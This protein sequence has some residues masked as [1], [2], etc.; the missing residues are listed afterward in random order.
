MKA[1]SSSRRRFLNL[2]AFL[3]AWKK[4]H[5]VGAAQAAGAGEWAHLDGGVG[6]GEAIPRDVP[7]GHTVV[8]V[9]EELRRYVV[10]VSSLDHPLFRELL[11][12][13]RDEYGFA[14]ADTRLCI[15]CDEDAFL[16]V[17]CHVDA[18]RESRLALCS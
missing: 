4:L 15:P 5:L 2:R 1:G 17:L 12:R 18:E 9:G 3:H 11:D 16:G 6:G 10:R 13:A 8:Y 14:A 7:R